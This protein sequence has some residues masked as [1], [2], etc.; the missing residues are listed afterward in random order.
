MCNNLL[1]VPYLLVENV[2]LEAALTDAIRKDFLQPVSAFSED[3]HTVQSVHTSTV[4]GAKSPAVPLD[5]YEQTLIQYFYIILGILLKFPDHLVTYD[6]YLT[7]GYQPRLC[8]TSKWATVRA[9]LVYQLGSLY[10]HKAHSESRHSDDGT[11]NACNYFR[12]SAGCFQWLAQHAQHDLDPAAIDT[13]Q[14]LM[15][16]QA[17]EVFWHK[18]IRG[19]N[20]KNSLVARLSM[21]VSDT[22]GKALESGSRCSCIVLEWVNFMKV[23]QLHFRAASLYRASL[24]CL[25]N[26]QYG[27]QV[28][29]LKLACEA[30]NEASRC[31]LYVKERVLEDLAGLTST[32]EECLRSAE[33][34]NDLVYLQPVPEHSDLS[35]IQGISMVEPQVPEP[36]LAKHELVF[37]ALLP[38]SIIQIGQAFKERQ[39]EYIAQNVK[40]PLAA[41][42][43]MFARYLAS[44]NLPASLDTLQRTESIPDSIADQSCEIISMGGTQVIERSM[45]DI[46]VLAGNCLELVSKCQERIEME[47]KED[48]LMRC[49]EG[50]HRWCRASSDEASAQFSSRLNKM[51]EYL[52]LGKGSDKLIDQSYQRIKPMIETLC[53]G[54]DALLRSI[55]KSDYLKLDEALVRCVSD[56]RN[57]LLEGH[58]MELQ[59]ERF[60]SS[61]EQKSRDQNILSSVISAARRDIK[62]YQDDQGQIDSRKFEPIYEKQVKCFAS[63]LEYVQQQKKQQV[64][65]EAAI[66]DANARFCAA[67]EKNSHAANGARF[68]ALQKFHNAYV[69]YLEL[70]ANLSQASTF[71]SDFLKKGSLVLEEIDEYLY[72]RRQEARDLGDH[73]RNE[74]NSEGV[75]RSNRENTNL[76]A[77]TGH[78]AFTW[79]S[80][81][82]VRFG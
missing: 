41:L 10:C 69:D 22:Y 62:A 17:R 61:L 38:F 36:L 15:L 35:A 2:D 81:K 13:L 29:Y 14:W 48:D 40:E 31:K 71:Y 30:C 34:D 5:Q 45:N 60:L 3:L 51:R 23:K 33:K 54:R 56:L 24:Q 78:R 59:R 18:A 9:N 4:Q 70:M 1:D 8:P 77:P 12:L 42:S 25:D 6:W 75:E 28:A 80:S 68:V 82:D 65:L 55:P 67:K 66:T 32:V 20:V 19:A 58:D 7:L 57:L 39:D 37:N 21:K 11:R 79:D 46:S 64:D 27:L 72:N 53:G 74:D 50:S 49:R 76:A 52:E 43:R 44:Q 16:A 47:K 73:I 26:F 63:D